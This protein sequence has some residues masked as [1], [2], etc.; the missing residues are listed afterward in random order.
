MPES[1]ESCRT[2]QETCAT[3]A[4]LPKNFWKYVRKG[5]PD[6][7]WEWFGHKNLSG[8]GQC[9]LTLAP[10]VYRPAQVH[11]LSYEHFKGPIP[12]GH[13][14]CHS[15]DNRP[16]INPAH[17]FTGTQKDNLADMYAKG[18]DTHTKQRQA[19]AAARNPSQP[20]SGEYVK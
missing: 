10:K 5:A 20:P 4:P 6:E 3:G 2:E 9:N 18:R 19:R 15:C 8:Y 13:H 11:R 12:E 14:V 7:C 17:L 1:A 16:C